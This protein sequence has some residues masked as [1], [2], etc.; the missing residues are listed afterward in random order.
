M[1]LVRRATEP[2][3]GEWALPGGVVLEREPLDG[4]ARRVFELRTGITDAYLEQLYT[5]ETRTRTPEPHR[6]RRLLRPPARRQAPGDLRR[7][8]AGGPT[9]SRSR[10]FRTLGLRP[11]PD[12]RLC[13]PAAGAEDRLTPLAFRVIR[14][15][16]TMAELRAV[17][18]IVQGEKL[19]A[20]NFAKMIR[21]RWP[22]VPVK[23]STSAPPTGRPAQLFRYVGEIEIP[24]PPKT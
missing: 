1:L 7:G 9:G 13:P 3:R 22:V 10:S 16:F 4:A 11:R 19:N 23:G 5:L 6:F 21:G 15:A 20:S 17:Y 12:R 18:E 8:C 14:D 24:G 2:F